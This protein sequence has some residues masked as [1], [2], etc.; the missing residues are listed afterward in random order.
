MARHLQPLFRKRMTAAGTSTTQAVTVDERRRIQR[1]FNRF[2]S[3]NEPSVAKDAAATAA[4]AP[5]TKP[6]IVKVELLG[7]ARFP[8]LALYRYDLATGK[9]SL[10]FA[11][12][13][14][15]EN[16]K[17]YAGTVNAWPGNVHA[18]YCEYDGPSKSGLD[19]SVYYLPD[20]P[21]TWP[22]EVGEKAGARKFE[23]S[24]KPVPFFLRVPLQG[25]LP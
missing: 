24:N 18:L 1:T 7:G 17:G 16:D 14:L 6:L 19:I 25:S 12:V 20:D 23:A 9:L 4:A 3:N 15:V 11:P 10:D 13:K 2:F 22:P 8:R 5:P 21:D